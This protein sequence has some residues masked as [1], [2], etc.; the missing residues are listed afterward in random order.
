MTATRCMSLEEAATRMSGLITPEGIAKGLAF[1]LRPT[2]VVISPYGKCGTTWTQQI[3]HTLRT[4]ADM[5]F[6]DI[7]RIVPWIETSS[8]LGID[9][10]LEQRGNPRAFKS[11][12]GWGAVPKG[13][14]YIV[15][16]R[17]PGDA[18]VSAYKFQEGWFLEPG[19]V[20]LDEFAHKRYLDRRG[21]D[22][23]SHLLSW[24]P[25]RG[26]PDVLLLA[27]EEMKADLPGTVRRI[28][29]FLGITLDAELEALTLEHASLDFMTRHKDRFDDFLMRDRSEKVCGLP[30]GSDSAKVRAGQVGSRSVLSR[31]VLD[32]LDD[33]WRE[34]VAAATGLP[35]YAALLEALRDGVPAD[36]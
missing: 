14:R 35:S 22:Y 23:W 17:D 1:Q 13:G 20:S 18:L 31:E 28:A 16:V 11:H 25:Q 21:R 36:A 6:D 3:V 27:Y 15:P 7:S 4:R 29:A 24:W 34:T 5:D 9:L 2:D 12:L 19:A 26:N 30:P 33:A 10:T 8:D 32:A